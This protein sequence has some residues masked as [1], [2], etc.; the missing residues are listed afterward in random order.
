MQRT[1]ADA[2]EALDALP[3][4]SDEQ[5]RAGQAE[6]AAAKAAATTLANEMADR[7]TIEIGDQ[8]QAWLTELCDVRDALAALRAEGDLGRISA[9]EYET[10][11]RELQA[12]QRHAERSVAT[13]EHTLAF[14]AVVEDDPLAYGESLLAKF[15]GTRPT[16]SF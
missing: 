15:P 11:L 14:V 13:V 5:R 6:I 7:H 3:G 2:T 8:R 12:R 9:A 10:Q 16:F 1:I 4:I